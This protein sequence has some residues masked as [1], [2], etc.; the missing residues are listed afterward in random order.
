MKLLVRSQTRFKYTIETIFIC[1]ACNTRCSTNDA[2]THFVCQTTRDGAPFFIWKKGF[3]FEVP[4]EC[5]SV[6][7]LDPL[8]VSYGDENK[9]MPNARLL[10]D[11]GSLFLRFFASEMY[12][13][14]GLAFVDNEADRVS[15]SLPGLNLFDELV[16]FQQPGS[17]SP[18]I[19]FILN[20]SYQLLRSHFICWMACFA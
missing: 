1:P 13:F 6:S 3:L 8:L 18:P 16:T 15:F 2:S 17:F 20:I 12:W 14:S 4:T 11:Y 9:T 19:L 5:F 7:A 10:M